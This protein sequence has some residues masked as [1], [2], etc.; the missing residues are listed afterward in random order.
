MSDTPHALVVGAGLAGSLMSTMLA[1]RGWKVDV[2]E[3]RGDLRLSTGSA[4]RSINLALST[5]GVTALERVGLSAEVLGQTIPMRGRM[6]H[7]VHGALTFQ[8]YGQQGQA[9]QSV[10]RRGLNELL[11]D[12]AERS[13]NVT[14]H[15]NQRCVDVDL[16]APSAT[17]IDAQ[18]Q[19]VTRR[20]DLLVGCDGIFSAV[21]GRMMR[22]DRFDYEQLYLK[23]GYE[24][25]ILRVQ[26][27]RFNWSRSRP[28]RADRR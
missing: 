14:M 5:R 1:R 21:R 18:G 7:D 10:S 15:F 11:I 3:R 23:H 17:F 20:A 24:L 25:A 6:M 8:P 28:G 4:G 19:R 12:I 27:V 13:P 16:D 9:I 26:T 2:V 22:T